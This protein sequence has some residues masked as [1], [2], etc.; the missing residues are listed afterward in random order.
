M[1]KKKD[2]MKNGGGIKVELVIPSFMKVEGEQ[3]DSL[4]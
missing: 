3:E 2:A 1:N 4:V